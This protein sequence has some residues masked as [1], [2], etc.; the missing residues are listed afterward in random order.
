MATKTEDKGVRHELSWSEVARLSFAAK[1][2]SEGLWK[3]GVRMTFAAANA[4]PSEDEVLPSGIVGIRCVALTQVT[5]PG[6]LVFDAGKRE[7]SRKTSRARKP[8]GP[9]PSV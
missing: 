5:E 3:I 2:I 7:A 6:P 8:R 1:G 9:G 4:G